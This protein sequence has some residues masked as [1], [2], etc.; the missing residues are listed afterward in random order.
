MIG[1]YFTVMLTVVLMWPEDN[2][3]VE[4][5]WVAVLQELHPVLSAFVTKYLMLDTL[6]MNQ[7]T[8]Q[9]TEII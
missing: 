8:G 9:N 1:V 6:I 4:M 2:H 7:E 3:T 5:S